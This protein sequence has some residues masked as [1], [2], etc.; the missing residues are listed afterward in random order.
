M[1][2]QLNEQWLYIMLDE[3]IFRSIIMGNNECVYWAGEGEDFSGYFV[4]DC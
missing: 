3:I 1:H 4:I 2:S